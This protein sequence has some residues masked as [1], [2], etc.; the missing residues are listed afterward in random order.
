MTRAGREIATRARRILTEMN[1]LEAVAQSFRDPLAGD[2]DVGLIP[3]IA[4]YLPA[5]ILCLHC[6]TFC[7]SCV[8]C[9]MSTQTGRAP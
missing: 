5:P 7:R 3:T 1:E 4:P 8:L 2:L 6:S 9:C